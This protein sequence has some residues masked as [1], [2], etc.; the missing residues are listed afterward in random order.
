M[1]GSFIQNYGK[2]RQSTTAHFIVLDY[3]FRPNGHH[4]VKLK[5]KRTHIYVYTHTVSYVVEISKPNDWFVLRCID[6]I[7]RIGLRNTFFLNRLYKE[8]INVKI[9]E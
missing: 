1:H 9:K 8:Y 6:K 2:F 7:G 3:T 4:Q 5:N